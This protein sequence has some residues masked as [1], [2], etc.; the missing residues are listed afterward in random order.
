MLCILQSGLFIYCRCLKRNITH[1][2]YVPKSHKQLD[3]NNYHLGQFIRFVH[4]RIQKVLSEGVRSN[5]D[6][7]FFLFFFFLNDE[8]RKVPNATIKRAIIDPRA[9]RHFNGVSLAC[10]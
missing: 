4:A 8:G 5:F 6:N 2:R 3:V 1:L 9:K 7:V 10:R